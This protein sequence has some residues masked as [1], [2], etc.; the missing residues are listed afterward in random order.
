MEKFEDG[1]ACR[2]FLNSATA[3]GIKDASWDALTEDQ[4]QVYRDFTNRMPFKLHDP[5]LSEKFTPT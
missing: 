3:W 4:R 5:S 2:I 1:L